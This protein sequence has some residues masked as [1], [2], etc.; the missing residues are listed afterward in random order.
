MKSQGKKGT[1][2]RARPKARNIGDEII[3]GLEE[4]VRFEHSEDTG[5]IVHDVLVSARDATVTPAPDYT[6][7]A[8]VVVR[9]LL[10]LTQPV[11]AQALNVS[12]ETVK[13]WEQ[14]KFPPQGAAKRLL[15]IAEKSPRAL[16]V[17]VTTKGKHKG[18]AA[19][20]RA[21]K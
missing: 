18:K 13:A 15:Q 6:P 4:A 2:R 5:A 11:F 7:N 3:A 12:P 20:R 16:L 21:V 19:G 17:H 9:K 8:I 10:G 14:G 1:R